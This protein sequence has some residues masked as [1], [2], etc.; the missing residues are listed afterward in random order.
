MKFNLTPNHITKPRVGSGP[1]TI[2]LP[3]GPCEVNINCQHDESKLLNCVFLEKEAH[4]V[5]INNGFFNSYFV[6]GDI[7]I[8]LIKMGYDLTAKQDLKKAKANKEEIITEYHRLSESNPEIFLSDNT[9]SDID[10]E[11]LISSLTQKKVKKYS[12]Y[13]NIDLDELCKEIELFF[14]SQKFGYLSEVEPQVFIDTDK[15]NNKMIKCFTAKTLIKTWGNTSETAVNVILNNKK[16][17]LTIYC[18]FSGNK[19]VL[20]G[21]GVTGAILTGGVSLIGNAASAVKD[22]KLVDSTLEYI[23]DLLS[24]LFKESSNNV[25][26]DNSKDIPSQIEKLSALKEKGIITEEEFNIKKTELLAK[27]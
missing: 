1:S 21:Q 7:L 3:S 15:D 8:T 20:S 10:L 9:S 22:K 18:G 24:N 26:I 13:E 12:G 4:C 6:C 23:D 11:Q 16:N 19:A 2:Q 27:M 25:I 17:N 5:L 14:K